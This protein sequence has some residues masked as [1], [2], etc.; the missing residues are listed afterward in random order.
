[1]TSRETSRCHIPGIKAG[2]GRRGGERQSRNGQ[3]SN[4]I[5]AACR[6]DVPGQRSAGEQIVKSISIEDNSRSTPQRLPELRAY[7]RTL[8]H[9]WSQVSRKRQTET[10][11]G[12]IRATLLG[13]SDLNLV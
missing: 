13:D 10:L 3:S 4:R 12:R 7:G 6:K 2:Y 1:M 11:E 5:D 9:C 8:V